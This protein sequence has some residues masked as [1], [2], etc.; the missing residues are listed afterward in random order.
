M[1]GNVRLCLTLISFLIPAY[2]VLCLEHPH[3]NVW[4]RNYERMDPIHSSYYA[5][6]MT[7]YACLWLSLHEY[8]FTGFY[9]FPVEA[10]VC[11][12]WMLAVANLCLKEQRMLNI[13]HAALDTSSIHPSL[14]P[15]D[16]LHNFLYYFSH[17]SEHTRTSGLVCSIRI[18]LSVV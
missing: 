14:H 18:N 1:S 2:S 9:S 16:Q 5:F 6:C 4:G 13:K 17:F 10:G 11:C 8:T 12:W 3:R 7:T 15:L